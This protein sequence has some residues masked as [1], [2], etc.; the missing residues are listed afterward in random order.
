MKIQ[1]RILTGYVLIAALFS[2]MSYGDFVMVGVVRQE[3]SRLVKETIPA[4]AAVNGVFNAGQMMLSAA[5]EFLYLVQNA[6]V[7]GDN[8]IVRQHIDVEIKEYREARSRL[9]LHLGQYAD[10]V[11][12]VFPHERRNLEILQAR[13]DML[14]ALADEF[15]LRYSVSGDLGDPLS[16]KVRLEEEERKFLE[17][18]ERIYFLENMEITDRAAKTDEQIRKFEIFSLA[19][20]GVIFLLAVGI[21][22]IIARRIAKPVTEL[23]QAARRIAHGGDPER[24]D[25][26]SKDE[27][28]QLAHAF[29]S[30]VVENQQIRKHL[31]EIV[32]ERTIRLEDVNEEL[33]AE[34][35][36]HEKSAREK[37]SL[38][39]RLIKSQKMEAIG[40][41][42]GGIAHD[43]NNI[44]GAILGYTELSIGKAEPGSFMERNL[45]GVK[46]SVDR[47]SQLTRQILA[48]SRQAKKELTP[49]KV[50]PVV[51]EVVSM[52]RASIPATIEIRQQVAKSGATAIILA[53]LGQV[54]Q[55]LMNLCVNAYHAMRQQGHGVLTLSVDR[56]LLGETEE[57]AVE[58]RIP[59]G[60][61]LRIEVSDTGHGIDQQIL[62]KIFDPY[63]STKAQGEGT[64]LGLAV[65]LGIVQTFSGYI[66][67]QSEVGCGTTF[68]VFLP[69]IDETDVLNA[70]AVPAMP[71]GNERILF[72]DDEELIAE[73]YAEVLKGLGYTVTAVTSSVEALGIFRQNPD[74][75]DCLITDMTMPEM[76]GV[77]LVREIFAIR[78][79]FP[80]ILCTGFSE[81][82]NEERAKE[83]GVRDF[84]M[85][86]MLVSQVA[87]SVRRILDGVSAGTE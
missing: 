19:S 51:N 28:G 29:N 59:P 39:D 34:I 40:T 84:I 86:P 78:P 81:T 21:G 54:H 72:V 18:L 45:L 37:R 5:Q 9:Y 1:G 10:L 43:F 83:L 68:Q 67:V 26:S 11:I 12:R 13:S 31:E 74:G 42:A 22:I 14:C 41:L 69:V 48:F 24:V 62:P 44:L 79:N 38:E 87:L 15:L 7:A 32:H 36:R 82:M 56:I 33:R 63:F 16:Q 60:S 8:E 49:V 46:S 52:L 55:V 75:F 20:C 66:R 57:A 35:R 30:M 25:I 80:V 2:V 76:T 58:C 6:K 73:S 77:E 23:E 65:V 3:A 53:D 47:A 27:V 85:K 17:I 50:L 64:G 4:Q 71:A 61:Y 70:V